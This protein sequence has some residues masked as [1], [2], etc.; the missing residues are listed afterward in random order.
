MGG[1]TDIKL[2]KLQRPNKRGRRSQQF[3]SYLVALPGEAHKGGKSFRAGRFVWGTQR[4]TGIR[5]ENNRLRKKKEEI[6]PGVAGGESQYLH[7]YRDGGGG[8]GEM[9]EQKK[10]GAIERKRE[11]RSYITILGRI[12]A[13]AK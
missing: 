10:G 9:N 8:M 12:T 11:K 5:K 2:R 13:H 1:P 4:K 3:D 6:L 7:S